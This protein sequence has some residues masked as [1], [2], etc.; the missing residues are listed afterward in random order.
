MLLVLYYTFHLLSYYS[1][2]YPLWTSSSKNHVILLLLI[3]YGKILIYSSS[4]TFIHNSLNLLSNNRDIFKN[5]G[6]LFCI[7]S[8]FEKY[9][10]FA[11][12]RS[13]QVDIFF[14]IIRIA[15]N[16]ISLESLGNRLMQYCSE[17]I[18]TD[19]I[20]FFDDSLGISET[21]ISVQIQKSI[22]IS[23]DIVFDGFLCL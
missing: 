4:S 5:S 12:A 15:K 19:E 11:Y 22:P 1:P 18:R 14:F 3:S 13:N 9:S 8:I 2:K 16:S 10:S 20:L 21:S 17:R 7:L 23:D 6:F